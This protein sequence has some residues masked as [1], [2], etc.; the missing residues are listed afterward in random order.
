M[1]AARRQLGRSLAPAG[2]SQRESRPEE[3]AAAVAAILRERGGEVEVLFILR[4]EREG[5]PWSGHMAFPGGRR[6]PSDTSLLATAVRETREEIGLD[7]AD[8]GVLVGVLEDEDA[9]GRGSQNTLFIRPFVFELTK[10]VELTFNHEVAAAMWV[11]VDPLHRGARGTTMSV[12]WK[13]QRYDMPGWDV[14]GRVVWGLTY[15]MMSALF[16]EVL[17]SDVLAASVAD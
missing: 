11:P 15:R 8:A 7:L 14:E 3:R 17:V 9:T 10:D 4:A 16:N 6:S 5:D 1:D 13:G 12:D 2:S